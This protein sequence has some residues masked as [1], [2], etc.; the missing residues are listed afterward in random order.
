MK[1]ILST[2]TILIIIMELSVAEA[3]PNEFER[4]HPDGPDNALGGFVRDV[5]HGPEGREYVLSTFNYIYSRDDSNSPWIRGSEQPVYGVLVD[6]TT[7]GR[8][9]AHKLRYSSGEIIESLDGGVTW[10]VI[11]DP[12]D[13]NVYWSLLGIGPEL[14]QTTYAVAS[15]NTEFGTSLDGGQSWLSVPSVN[16]QSLFNLSDFSVDPLNSNILYI[17]D[18]QEIKKSVDAGATWIT[19]DTG[20]G[21]FWYMNSLAMSQADP[22]VLFA[23]SGAGSMMFRSLNGGEN[24]MQLTNFP[25]GSGGSVNALAI[26]PNSAQIV[27]TGTDSGDASYSLDG[28]ETWSSYTDSESAVGFWSAAS[29]S[30][31][32]AAMLGGRLGIGF[33]NLADEIVYANDGFS[34]MDISTIVHAPSD[35]QYLYGGS[36]TSGVAVKIGGS[37]NWQLRNMGLSD[38]SIRGIAVSHQN[39]EVVFLSTPEQLYKTE[40]AGIDW[41]EISTPNV[42]G[43]LSELRFRRWT[44]TSFI[45]RLIVV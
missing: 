42:F 5:F 40:N 34:D 28:G 9:L 11:Y 25:F 7:P 29:I 38:L 15:G 21:Q 16:L 35:G 39:P 10:E 14:N 22:N 2:L 31:N 4:S 44:Q 17:L 20:V 36:L 19:H 33:P 12:F 41:L 37:P 23:G 3:A 32:G 45:Y 13:S 24:W 30:T 8:L 6:P 26:D 43:L 18:Q 27:I 1:E